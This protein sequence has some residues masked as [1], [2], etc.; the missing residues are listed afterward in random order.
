MNPALRQ[1]VKES[2][3]PSLWSLEGHGPIVKEGGGGGGGGMACCSA[4]KSLK[5]ASSM[6]PLDRKSAYVVN[7][8]SLTQ[9]EG[10]LLKTGPDSSRPVKRHFI[11]K[12]SALLEF[13]NPIS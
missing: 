8:K 11:L 2:L 9:M 4:T 6:N 13:N 1:A 3:K 5:K 7:G 10:P 12:D